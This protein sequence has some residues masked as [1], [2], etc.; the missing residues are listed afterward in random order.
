M[1]FI[2][3]RRYQ[4]VAGFPS[5]PRPELFGFQVP[6]GRVKSVL[7]SSSGRRSSDSDSAGGNMNRAR[8][9][10]S[11]L[12]KRTC[13][14]ARR[15][16]AQKRLRRLD[17]RTGPRTGERL[18]QVELTGPL[19]ASQGLSRPPGRQT[20]AD[21]L[22]SLTHRR[23]ERRRHG[24]LTRV[25]RPF[26]APSIGFPGENLFEP[27]AGAAGRTSAANLFE[28]VLRGC[29][30]PRAGDLVLRAEVERTSVR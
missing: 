12:A 13:P 30:P 1:R 20:I 15:A 4:E 18:G 10:S 11:A 17:T 5:P 27:N 28:Y 9:K 25:A 22:R 21:A 16:R 6:G 14:Q 2:P 24:I 23:E 26:G 29:G 19:D 7:G 8:L 3:A